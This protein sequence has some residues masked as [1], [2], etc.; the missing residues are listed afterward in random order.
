MHSSWG[1]TVVPACH[2][3][4]DFYATCGVS[5]A[6]QRYT[7]AVVRAE[8]CDGPP[9]GARRSVSEASIQRG[10]LLERNKHHKVTAT[11]AAAAVHRQHVRNVRV[12]YEPL[13]LGTGMYRYYL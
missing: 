1:G 11:A 4:L 2:R 5:A 8:A 10:D 3:L 13:Y 12:Q 6:A 7:N 9:P